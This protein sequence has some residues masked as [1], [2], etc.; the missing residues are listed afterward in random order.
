[1]FKH[2]LAAA[3]LCFLVGACTTDQLQLAQNDISTGIAAGCKDVNAALPLVADPAVKV[4]AVAACG[5]ATAVASLVQNS[6][7]I[8]W[9][10]QIKAQLDAAKVA[11]PA[12]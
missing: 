12:S 8:Q 10:G 7:T 5:T 2:L 6:G 11:A 1:M 3:G 9:L 4:Y